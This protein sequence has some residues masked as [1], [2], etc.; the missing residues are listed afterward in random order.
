MEKSDYRKQVM[1]LLPLEGDKRIEEVEKLLLLLK[2]NA[3]LNKIK[4]TNK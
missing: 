1:W 2:S 4:E 3:V